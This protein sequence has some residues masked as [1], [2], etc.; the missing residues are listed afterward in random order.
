MET[1][2][3]DLKQFTGWQKALH[4]NWGSNSCYRTVRG[5]QLN[6]THCRWRANQR[7]TKSKL[8]GIPVIWVMWWTCSMLTMGCSSRHTIETM[9]G[10]V[11]IV[12]S[13]VEVDGGTRTVHISTSMAYMDLVGLASIWMAHGLSSQHLEWCWR[14]SNIMLFPML[15]CACT[16]LIKQIWYFLLLLCRF[17][18]KIAD[19]LTNSVLTGYKETYDQTDY[20]MHTKNE[21]S[22]Q[23]EM[24]LVVFERKRSNW[25]SSRLPAPPKTNFLIM[26]ILP[27]KS[28]AVKPL[29]N[30]P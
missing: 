23:I 5:I 22:F 15:D 14:S 28:T 2:G 18:S 4:T 20:F 25:S 29:Q 21:F 11:A 9:I 13:Q 7:I 3:W 12:L 8:E 24:F 17:N 6:T 30:R 10:V 19:K 26:F 1:T 16:N 27:V